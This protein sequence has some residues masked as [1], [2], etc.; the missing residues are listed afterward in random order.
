MK[1]IQSIEMGEHEHGLFGV[2]KIRYIYEIEGQT[3][4]KLTIEIRGIKGLITY[5]HTGVYAEECYKKVL[6][7]M[8]EDLLNL[9]KRLATESVGIPLIRLKD[10]GHSSELVWARNM[11]IWFARTQLNYSFSK[12]AKLFFLNHSTGMYAVKT[13]ETKYQMLKIDEAHWKRRFL[14]RLREYGLITAKS[15]EQIK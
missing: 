9:V 12:A 2:G 4:K 14:L 6:G 10:R 7:D 5:V 15:F 11:V 13:F 1:K 3:V 8:D